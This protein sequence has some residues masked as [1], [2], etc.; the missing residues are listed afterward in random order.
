ME[1]KRGL[2]LEMPH[3]SGKRWIDPPFQYDFWQANARRM[4]DFQLSKDDIEEEIL[5][6]PQEFEPLISRWERGGY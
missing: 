5:S 1:Q 3:N 6:N 4:E 2:D